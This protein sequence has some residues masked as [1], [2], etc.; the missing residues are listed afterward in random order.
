MFSLLHS[1][2]CSDKDYLLDKFTLNLQW[3]PFLLAIRSSFHQIILV[4]HHALRC[5][6]F[7]LRCRTR[8]VLLIGTLPKY[9]DDRVGIFDWP[10][11]HS[12]HSMAT[13]TPPVKVEIPDSLSRCIQARFEIHARY[14]SLVLLAYV[15]VDLGSSR[16][17]RV[18]V[19][20]SLVRNHSFR[21]RSE[22]G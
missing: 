16:S 13:V 19:L 18:C 20:Q 12:F 5:L 6:L 4:R 1:N 17:L 9:A 11:V 7:E 3:N 14:S 15:A 2:A 21:L 22:R 10:V 8:L